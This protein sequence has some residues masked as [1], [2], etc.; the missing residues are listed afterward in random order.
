MAQENVF[1]I[2][3]ARKHF[4]GSFPR[5][6]QGIAQASVSMGAF[7]NCVLIPTTVRLMSD[8]FIL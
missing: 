7:C 1:L 5:I 3:S 2:Q 4:L 6:E 8:V